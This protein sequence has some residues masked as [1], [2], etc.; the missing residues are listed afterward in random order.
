MAGFPAK[1]LAGYQAPAKS[2]SGT[3]LMLI[4]TPDKIRPYMTCSVPGFVEVSPREGPLAG[5]LIAVQG[6]AVE[7]GGAGQL[8]RNL[9]VTADQGPTEDI[10]GY[11]TVNVYKMRIG[12]YLLRQGVKNI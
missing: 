12:R 8:G 7:A 4:N 1:L 10:S 11:L 6:H 5:D 2:V 9:Q 3:T